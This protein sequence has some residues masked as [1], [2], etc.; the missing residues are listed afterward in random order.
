MI[1]GCIK[2]VLAKHKSTFFSKTPLRRF[3]T[4]NSSLRQNSSNKKG[5][6][7]VVAQWLSTL[8]VIKRSTWFE[9]C[10]ALAFPHFFSHLLVVCPFKGGSA[11]I[12]VCF[13]VQLS[14]EQCKLCVHRIGL[15][16]PR[17][18]LS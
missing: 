10:R 1:N 4:K 3:E 7:A 6:N 12:F 13:S 11:F 2:F 9:S 14:L 18:K 8:L 5:P 17:E 16:C 15:I